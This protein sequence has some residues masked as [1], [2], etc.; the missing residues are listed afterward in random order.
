MGFCSWILTCMP[1][2][3]VINGD[4][5]ERQKC[6]PCNYLETQGGLRVT[7]NVYPITPGPMAATSMLTANRL[8]IYWS[9]ARQLSIWVRA[10]AGLSEKVCS[11][12][13][14]TK[15]VKVCTW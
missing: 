11:Q 2:S 4:K 14:Q 8:S 5:T 15:C 12:L 9:K 7:F 6:T 10:E 1:W 3:D 13:L